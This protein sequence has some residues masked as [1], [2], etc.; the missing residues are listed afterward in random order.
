MLYVE[1]IHKLRVLQQP[2]RVP[3]VDSFGW[4]F[5]HLIEVWRTYH[6]S[7]WQITNLPTPG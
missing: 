3:R 1:N 6:L 7:P 5:G 2:K 4:V